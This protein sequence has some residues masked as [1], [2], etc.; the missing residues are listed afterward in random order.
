MGHL[1][2]HGGIELHTTPVGILRRASNIELRFHRK[3]YD[4]T[5]GRI[6]G[7]VFLFVRLYWAEPFLCL[8]HAVKGWMGIHSF[9]IT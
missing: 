5:G 8:Y 7:T 2:Q 6:I 3:H 1:M 9:R 4:I